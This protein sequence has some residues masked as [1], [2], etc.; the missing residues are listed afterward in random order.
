M[1]VETIRVAL[2]AAEV[3]A[4][5]DIVAA[6]AEAKKAMETEIATARAE[7]EKAAEE[8]FRA[9]FFQGYDGLKRRVALAHLE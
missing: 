1:E 7:A 3:K 2:A 4:M 5:V 6:R 9:G 8:D